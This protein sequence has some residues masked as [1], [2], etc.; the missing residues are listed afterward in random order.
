MHLKAAPL[1]ALWEGV[2]AY[3]ILLFEDGRLGPIHVR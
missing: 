2:E 1:M 3:L